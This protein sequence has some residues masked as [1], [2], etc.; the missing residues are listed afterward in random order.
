MPTPPCRHCTIM[1]EMWPQGTLNSIQLNKSL[2]DGVWA[3][4]TLCLKEGHLFD[5]IVLHDIATPFIYLFICVFVYSAIHPSY[6]SIY[7]LI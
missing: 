3:K 7:L 1:Q 6:L 2:S 5:D 4:W